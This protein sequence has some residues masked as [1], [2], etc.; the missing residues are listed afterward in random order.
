LA[1]RV[2]PFFED[3]SILYKPLKHGGELLQN[4]VDPIRR[5]LLRSPPEVITIEEITVVHHA[6]GELRTWTT[7]NDRRLFPHTS[8]SVQ[9]RRDLYAKLWAELIA[10]SSKYRD[11]SPMHV[12]IATDIQNIPQN[13]RPSTAPKPDDPSS[14]T[15]SNLQGANSSSKS[16]SAMDVS[17]SSL[18]TTPNTAPA[19]PPTST[20]NSSA[21]S[22]KAAEN[23]WLYD[24]STVRHD[25]VGL[26]DMSWSGAPMTNPDVPLA[27]AEMNPSSLYAVYWNAAASLVKKQ[28]NFP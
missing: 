13:L 9:K 4:I 25:I 21:E 14:S 27:T 12:V 2:F 24:V 10:L 8:A 3:D 20:P 16:S 5:A 19:L 22:A 11:I 17:H 18:S 1:T 23:K 6:L 28:R 7:E 26:K 15:L